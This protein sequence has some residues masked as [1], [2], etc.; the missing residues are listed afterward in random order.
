MLEN[1]SED[2]IEEVQKSI[3]IGKK[4]GKSISVYYIITDGLFDYNIN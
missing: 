3:E 4:E 2:L 1:Y